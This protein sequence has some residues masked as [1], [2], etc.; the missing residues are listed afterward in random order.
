[1]KRRIFALC[2]ALCMLVSLGGCSATPSKFTVDDYATRVLEAITAKDTAVLQSLANADYAGYFSEQEMEPFYEQYEEWGVC[3]TG[4]KVGT[5]KRY[6]WQTS[7]DY[8][9]D[10]GSEACYT[11]SIGGILYDFEIVVVTNES[12]EGM[13]NFELERID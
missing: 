7:R 8:F 6:A 9:G 12:G 3:G 2:L 4:V 1:M 10:K 5:L 11:V 13:A